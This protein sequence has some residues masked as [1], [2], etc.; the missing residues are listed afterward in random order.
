MFEKY[1]FIKAFGSAK[2]YEQYTTEE[3]DYLLLIDSRINEVKN[4]CSELTHK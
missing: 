2:E 1:N 3:I 4:K